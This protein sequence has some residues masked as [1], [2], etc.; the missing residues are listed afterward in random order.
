V[1]AARAEGFLDADFA[2]ALGDRDEHDVHQADSA[3]AQRESADEAEQD[4]EAECD[5]L[6]L[7]EPAP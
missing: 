4:L 6:E 3:D 7:V 5:D 1:A 2:G